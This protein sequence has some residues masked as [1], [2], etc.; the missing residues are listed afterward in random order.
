ML[1]MAFG[2]GVNLK[3]THKEPY[4]GMDLSWNVVPGLDMDTDLV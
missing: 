2:L 1:E 3:V 4:P